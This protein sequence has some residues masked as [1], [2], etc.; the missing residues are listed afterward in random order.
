MG[1]DLDDRTDELLMRVQRELNVQLERQYDQLAQSLSDFVYS[2]FSDPHEPPW[3]EELTIFS[4]YWNERGL[5]L[6]QRT[7]DG[8]ERLIRDEVENADDRRPLDE[9]GARADESEVQGIFLAAAP[10]GRGG[11]G[12]GSAGK[13][14]GSKSVRAGKAP[15]P[16]RSLYPAGKWVE[17]IKGDGLLELDSPV[18]L[19]DGSW[20]KRIP[21]RNGKP[22]YDKWQLPGPEIMIAMTG[23]QKFDQA[24]ADKAWEAAGN[25]P[26]DRRRYTFHHDG[27]V[28]E[29]SKHR[30]Q[31]IFAGRMQPIPIALNQRSHLGTASIARKHLLSKKLAREV[32]ELM[33]QGKGPLT[34]LSK[35]F[36]KRIKQVRRFIPI[37]GGALTLVTFADEVEAHG[38][39]GAVARA[40]PLLGDI[41]GAYDLGNELAAEIYEA[42]D[43]MVRAAY[44]D[45]NN[46]VHDAHAAARTTT[47]AAFNEVAKHVHVEQ[48]Y[49][50]IDE[51]VDAI[52]E[53]I[54]DFYQEAYYIEF[55]NSQAGGAIS[56]ADAKQRIE[57]A[58]A[59]LEQQLKQRLKRKTPPNP[60]DFG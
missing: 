49:I 32:N 34:R 50:Q 42:S 43:A 39:V 48:E 12:K 36:A 7:L 46:P 11:K 25:R 3:R 35:V 5:R 60:S 27:H 10:R 2:V 23:D 54:A 40:T 38:A 22:I 33:L 15:G 28:M 58:K 51:I 45:A 14:D 19:P 26:L 4:E 9:F 37:V 47:A 17:G 41:I 29:M 20:V 6:T 8:L 31:T 1:F 30:G 57:R 18:E 55:K 21:F 59:K 56:P 24:Q 13:A 44:D 53:S 16:P 52:E